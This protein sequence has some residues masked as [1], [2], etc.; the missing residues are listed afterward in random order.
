MKRVIKQL[1]NVKF[2]VNNIL[3][4]YRQSSDNEIIEG[5]RWYQ[6]ANQIAELMSKKYNLPIETTAGIISAL[7]PG[8]NWSQ[9]IIDANHL[10][11]LLQAGKSIKAITC[12]TYGPNKFKAHYLYL[13]PQLTKNE[14]F[15]ILLGASKKVN[16]TSS[17]Y[18]NIL[19]P[20]SADIV[21][22]D[23]HAFRINLG[24]TD[25]INISLTEKRYL[26]MNQAYIE[27]SKLLEINAIALQAVTWLTFRR[28]N[29]IIRDKQFDEVPF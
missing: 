19:Q 25:M 28:L 6:Q 2:Q 22:I 20:D 11:S 9:N 29:N 17:F 24:I 27:A 13:N 7:S 3:E 10:I 12:T 26:T 5:C 4:I 1:N 14:I 23:R 18:L 16:K 8:T 15:K 21:T